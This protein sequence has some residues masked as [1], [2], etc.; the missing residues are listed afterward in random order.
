MAATPTRS[1]TAT[2]I[3]AATG[4][5]L[6]GDGAV[7]VSAVA[8]LD[9]ASSSDL[10]FFAD[11]RYAAA[12]A[13]SAAGVVLVSPELAESE[14][15]A[16][17]R[18]VV[19]KPHDALLALLPRLYVP[20]PF[21]PG[22][23]ATAI[24]AGATVAK[25]ARVDAY[26]VIGA[27]AKIGERAWI[28]PHCVVGEGVSVAEDSRLF[29]HV[30]L[31]PGAA[32]GARTVIHSG[33]QIGS[34]GFGFVY[35]DGAHRKIPHVGRCIIGNDVE[36]GANSAVDRGSIDD[37]VVGDGTKLDNFVHIAHNVRVGRLCLLMAHVG[38]AGSSRLDDGVIMAG[39]SGAAGHVHIGAQAR[40]A[41]RGGVIGDVPAGETW[42]GFPARPH[43]DALRASAALNRLAGII[44][45]LERLLEKS[46]E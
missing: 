24:V 23:H 46:G 39:Q 1:L 25:S 41:A 13:K 34:D 28:G 21:E 38:V 35:S 16:R 27:G 12:F 43:R 37:T 2:E 15:M 8:P 32:I 22:V 7:S 42:S 31:Y 5:S 17:A 18:V 19:A 14:G 33:C 45:R 6:V 29:P 20:P 11:A 40:I 9:R 36:I 4:G 26:A 30:T 44:K 10:S 3:A